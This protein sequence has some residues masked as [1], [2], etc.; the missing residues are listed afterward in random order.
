MSLETGGV[1]MIPIKTPL[2]ILKYGPSA[3]V[4]TQKSKFFLLLHGD[5]H[6]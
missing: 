2:V 3:L 5:V 6:A 4:A 1:R